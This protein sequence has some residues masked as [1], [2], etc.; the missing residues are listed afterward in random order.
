MPERILPILDLIFMTFVTIGLFVMSL[1]LLTL[2][3]T[4]LATLFWFGKIK[5][6]VDKNHNGKFIDY[7]KSIVKKNR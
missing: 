5:R 2:L 6:E 7:L 4:I 1:S 3:P